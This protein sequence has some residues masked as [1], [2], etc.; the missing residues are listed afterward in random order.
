MSMQNLPLAANS[1]PL[2]QAST[3]APFLLKVVR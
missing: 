1:R 2:E 3:Q